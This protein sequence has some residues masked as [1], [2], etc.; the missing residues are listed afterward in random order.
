MFCSSIALL[1]SSEL[2]SFCTA[3]M[4]LRFFSMIPLSFWTVP[5][6]PPC[7]EPVVSSL[8]SFET[9]SLSAL[10]SLA[11]PATTVPMTSLKPR[12]LALSSCLPTKYGFSVRS[13]E[14]M[15]CSGV[16]KLPPR[17]VMPPSCPWCLPVR[18]A[19][20]GSSTISWAFPN[21]S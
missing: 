4:A 17:T 6:L 21:M 12:S 10:T 13:A 16:R 14:V 5:S 7:A 2:F 8:P 18:V 20:K 15:L 9:S 19:L 11:L 1:F 3:S